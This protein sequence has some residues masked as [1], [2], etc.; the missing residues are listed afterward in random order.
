MLISAQLLPTPGF[1][2]VYVNNACILAAAGQPV[3]GLDNRPI[4]PLDLILL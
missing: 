3:L 2:E 4:P 1:E